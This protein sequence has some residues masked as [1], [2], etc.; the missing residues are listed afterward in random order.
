MGLLNLLSTNEIVAQI[1]S[2]LLLLFIL[3][4]FAWKKVLGLLDARKEKIAAELKAI[5]D[6]KLEIAKLRSEY[7]GRLTSISEEARHKIQEA[8]QEGK[9][10]QEQLK[11]AGNLEAQKIIESARDNIKYEIGKAKEEL[12]EKIIDISI[13]AAESVIEEKLTEKS[14]RNLVSN[15][16]KRVGE[17]K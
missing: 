6:T 14:D 5:E 7:E 13:K 9:E 11:K 12:K 8:V 15:F 1:A 2:F 17:M 10:L 4:V 3:R 16:L